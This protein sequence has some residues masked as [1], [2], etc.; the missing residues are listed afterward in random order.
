MTRVLS[1]AGEF[2]SSHPLRDA[3]HHPSALIALISLRFMGHFPIC[4]PCPSTRLPY[5]EDLGKMQE[6]ISCQKLPESS[7]ILLNFSP[8]YK[9]G[10]TN[11]SKWKSPKPPSQP[12]TW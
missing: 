2:E 10:G 4:H 3:S 6:C 5:Q 1:Y 11:L 7:S 8:E 12:I 9:L